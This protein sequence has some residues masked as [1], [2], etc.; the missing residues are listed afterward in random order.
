MSAKYS[1]NMLTV[2]R[3]PIASEILKAADVREQ[4][5]HDL[6]A[7]LQDIAMTVQYLVHDGFGHVFGHRAAHALLGGQVLEDEQHANKLVVDIV[8]WHHVQVERHARAVR[9]DDVDIQR[10]AGALLAHRAGQLYH[11]TV[12]RMEQRREVVANHIIF[13]PV[14]E[15]LAA[16]RTRYAAQGQR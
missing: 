14:Q 7:T 12:L 15:R 6:R 11:P 8:E 13:P 4:Q 2:A 9:L 1:F 10:L 16:A 5:G 3:G